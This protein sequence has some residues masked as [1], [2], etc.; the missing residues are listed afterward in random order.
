M[1]HIWHS[2]MVTAVEDTLPKCPAMW[3]VPIFVAVFPG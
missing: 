1:V 2:G 3:T